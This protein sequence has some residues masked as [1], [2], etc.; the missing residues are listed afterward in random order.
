MKKYKKIAG[1]NLLL[2]RGLEKGI[3]SGK[4]KKTEEN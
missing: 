3:F 4:R 2:I 1:I